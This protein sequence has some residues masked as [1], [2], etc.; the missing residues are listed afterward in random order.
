MTMA[1]AWSVGQEAGEWLR[2]DQ[3]T[4]VRRLPLYRRAES[5]EGGRRSQ[6]AG[7]LEGAPEVELPGVPGPGHDRPAA[8]CEG[9]LGSWGAGDTW[10]G[11]RCPAGRPSSTCPRHTGRLTG[12]RWRWGTPRG[13]GAGR[14]EEGNVEAGRVEEGR[15][16]EARVV[17]GRGG[18]EAGCSRVRWWMAGCRKVAGGERQ[19]EGRQGAMTPALGSPRPVVDYPVWW[20][21]CTPHHHHLP[22][23]S[24]KQ[25]AIS[26]LQLPYI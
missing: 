7:V 19:D 18:G 4:R 5:N 23:C 1:S 21:S 12:L 26:A 16:Q 25:T 2:G 17:E 8:K 22:S 15:G 6:P 9:E 11:G 24:N 10:R 13:S 14:R 20:G 3:D